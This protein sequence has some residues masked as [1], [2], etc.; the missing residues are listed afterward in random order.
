MKGYNPLT[1]KASPLNNDIMGID[2]EGV[3]RA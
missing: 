1:L 3:V 2:P